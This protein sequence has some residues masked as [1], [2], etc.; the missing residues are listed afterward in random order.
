MLNANKD[1]VQSAIAIA[2]GQSVFSSSIQRDITDKIKAT[3]DPRFSQLKPNAVLS[4]GPTGLKSFAQDAMIL[5]F[6]QNTYATAVRNTMYVALATATV[7]IPFALGM[8]WL[9]VKK[10]NKANVPA[11]KAVKV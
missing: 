11:T 4:A 2:I 10:L 6:L 8:Q 3:Q 9:N 5:E 7:A 1:I